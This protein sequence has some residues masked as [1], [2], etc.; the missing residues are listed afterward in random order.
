MIL[1]RKKKTNSYI[2]GELSNPD[3]VCL[4][5]ERPDKGNAPDVSC[6]PVGIY[7]CKRIISPKFGETFEVTGVPNRSN[8]EFHSGNV[9]ED[10]HGCIILGTY[11]GILHNEFAV[12]GSKA[13]FQKFMK[14]LEGINT[15][16]LEVR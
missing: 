1:N 8:I 13:A 11:E 14:S 12:L 10:S 16:Q 2:F 9:V 15:F 3:F 4:T 5:L 7:T 6:I